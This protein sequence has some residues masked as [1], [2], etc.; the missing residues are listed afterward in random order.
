MQE[1]MR[2]TAC[3]SG[4]EVTYTKLQA[5]ATGPTDPVQ[6]PVSSFARGVRAHADPSPMM[7]F[8]RCRRAA[9][10]CWGVWQV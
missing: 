3:P 10:T 9:G 5:S 1:I 4:P 2:L 6:A 7:S 8:L